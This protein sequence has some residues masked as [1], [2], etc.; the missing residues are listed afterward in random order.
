MNKTIKYGDY[1]CSKFK[2]MLGTNDPR[3]LSWCDEVAPYLEGYSLYVYGGI[4]ENWETYDIDGT[5]AGPFDPVRVNDILKNIVR[6]S[7]EH[8]IFPDIKYNKEGK[9]FTWSE[10]EKTKEPVTIEYA[11]YQPSMIVNGKFI[12]WGICK[13]SLWTA[14]RTWPLKKTIFKKHIYSDPLKLF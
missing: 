6:I 7:F 8:S 2:P 4:L 13:E 12:E 3:F 1:T 5:L 14:S 9:L 11:Y 10:Y